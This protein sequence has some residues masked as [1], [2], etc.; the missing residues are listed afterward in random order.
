MWHNI[1]SELRTFPQWV[2]SGPDKVP[3]NPR[4]GQ[5]ASSTDPST[6]ATFE[7]AIKSGYKHVGFVLSTTDPYTIIDLDNKPDRPLTQEQWAVHE[8]ILTAFDSYTERSASGRGYHIIVRGKVPAGVK[9]K[10]SVE[11]YSTA[12]YMVCT[13]DVV[14]PTPIGDYQ[15]LLDRLY[16]EMLPAPTI[17]LDESGNEILDDRELVD[18]AMGAVNG[19]KFTQLCNG[20]WPS[21]GYPSQSEADFALM[22]MFAY[23]T[24]DNEQCR[25]L[26]RMTNLG[27]RDKAQRDNTYL[28]R[29][30][31]KMRAREPAMVDIDGLRAKAEQLVNGT[32]IVEVPVTAHVMTQ[33]P[34]NGHHLKSVEAPMISPPPT[35]PPE[36]RSLAVATPPGAVLKG[37]ELPPGLI[38][39]MA[40]YFYQSATRPVPEV[41]LAAAISLVSG[42]CGR[43]YNVS[44]TGLN[45]YIIL[46]AKTGTGKEGAVTGID[47]LIAAVR[48][49]IPMVDQFMG[50]SAF[51][52][53]QA[54]IKVLDERPCFV[55][56]L[57]EFGLTLQQL[58]DARASS[59]QIMLRKVMLDLYTKSGWS[60]VLRSSVY[61]D[62]EKNTKVIQ[63]P[64]VTILGES[65]PETFFNGLDASH[66]SEGLIPRF[67]IVN[68]DGARP[69]RN[70][71]ANH[72]PPIA[73]TTKFAELVAVA[74]TTTNNQTCMSV[75]TDTGATAMLDEFD[76]EADDK[77]NQDSSDVEKQLWNRAHLKALKLSALLAVGVNPH[78]PIVN[79]ALAT[80]AIDFIR[81]D[82]ELMS[83]RFKS[84]D[85]GTGDGKLLYDLKRLV[86]VYLESPFQR[87][88]QYGVEDYMHKD[89]V[90][91][92]IYLQR[93]TAN[94]S[95]FKG[96]RRGATGALRNAIQD[97]TDSGALDEIPTNQMR[98]R[99]K[100]SAKAYVIGPSFGRGGFT[101]KKGV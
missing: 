22:S 90:I 55:S 82:V 7:E 2:V 48:P 35:V 81:R 89:K 83:T 96:D 71:N 69:R 67:I 32:K 73:L 14:R 3:L 72:P 23:Y 68:Y 39:E 26:F 54:M 50:P 58:C 9:N 21:M 42:V 34:V 47:N 1:P 77:I 51:A 85:I 5:P 70:P 87:I 37:I 100:T 46:I 65:T 24:K 62:V 8:R 41:A 49:Q 10:D 56:V 94:L 20:D 101:I 78:Q 59:A 28:N 40:L 91:P 64:A 97:A 15:S 45:Q 16:G 79:E 43:S 30:L 17:E 53:G 76:R 11:V 75:Q 4:T 25:R 92:Y 95:A 66:V 99:Y 27:K 80:W 52:S 33:A 6:W 13:G 86:K 12:R 98:T 44:G 88:E 61:S 63:A 57:G 31:S 18:M 19:A 93:R 36:E 29:M 60:K 84:G 74:L 38:G